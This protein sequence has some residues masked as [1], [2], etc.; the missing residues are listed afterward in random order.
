[1][2]KGISGVGQGGSA[3]FYGLAG[4]SFVFFILVCNSL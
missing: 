4:L 3:V 1:M 2:E